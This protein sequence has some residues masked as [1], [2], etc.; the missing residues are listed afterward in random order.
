VVRATADC[1]NVD[2][3]K[4]P[5]DLTVANYNGVLNHTLECN[6]IN[7]VSSTRSLLKFNLTLLEEIFMFHLTV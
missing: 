1:Q 6:V 3:E 4:G 5:A 2:R 7:Y